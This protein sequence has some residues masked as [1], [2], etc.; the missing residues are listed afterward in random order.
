MWISLLLML[1]AVPAAPR[2]TVAPASSSYCYAAELIVVTRDDRDEIVERIVSTGIWQF[3]AGP[4]SRGEHCIAADSGD[5]TS[6]RQLL[7][8]R[9]DSAAS[10]S[11]E[12][13]SYV[14]LR[15]TSLTQMRRTIG[16]IALAAASRRGSF[17]RLELLVAPVR[18]ANRGVEV[19]LGAMV[20]DS[21]DATACAT[22]NSKLP[23]S[24]AFR[25]AC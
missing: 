13:R 6:L 9:L 4:A 18:S 20:R 5:F 7:V 2:R 8:Q 16:A 14:E 15:D 10:S 17:K 19:A 11:A 23:G 25:W 3:E 24:A 12:H 22:D 21:A 1:S